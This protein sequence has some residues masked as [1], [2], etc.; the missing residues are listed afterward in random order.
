[1][2]ET[3]TTNLQLLKVARA[4]QAIQTKLFATRRRWHEKLAADAEAQKPEQESE[5]KS[6]EESEKIKR[7]RA[8]FTKNDGQGK[9]TPE[10][11]EQ[12][13]QQRKLKKQKNKQRMTMLRRKLEVIE[14]EKKA[15]ALTR[16]L[17]KL[18]LAIV[19]I[20]TTWNNTII[21]LTDRR[22]RVKLWTSAGAQRSTRGCKKRS[23]YANSLAADEVVNFAR[24]KGVKRL[25]IVLSGPGTGRKWTVKK[26]IRTRTW[27]VLKIRSKRNIPHG[28]C[29]PP[30]RPRRRRR[31]FKG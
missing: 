23:G 3:E 10:Q 28:G 20:R 12:K 27:R 17:A 31:G 21:S 30:K 14:K 1:M 5:S 7:T 22:G 15:K 29:R 13:R 24:R 25:G 16:R 6:N 18:E 9:Y 19:A 2:T 8:E 26:F 4:I 11:R